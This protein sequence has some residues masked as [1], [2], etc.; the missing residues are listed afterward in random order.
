VNQSLALKTHIYYII[1]TGPIER[2]IEVELSELKNKISQVVMMGVDGV[3][4]SEKT[5]RR[6]ERGVGGIILFAHNCRHP[7]QVAE[8]T[9]GL[10]KIALN[11]EL[12]IPL[13]IAIDQEHGPVVRIREGVTPFPSPWD[14]GRSMNVSVVRRVAQITGKELLLMGINMN[15]A[16]V[17]DLHMH[18]DNQVIGKRSFGRDPHMV[19][20]MV[21]AYI[22]GLQGE[23]VAA[24]A[25]HF[26]GHGATA[27]DSHQELPI[28]KKSK[29]KLD[30]AELLPFQM[31][32]NAGVASVMTGHLL[33]PVLDPTRPATL[34]H[35]IIQGVLRRNLGFSGVVISDDLTMGALSQWGTIEEIGVEALSSG[36]DFLLVGHGNVDGLLD[37]LQRGVATGKISRARAADAIQRILMLKKHYPYRAPGDLS[38]LRQKNDLAFSQELFRGVGYGEGDPRD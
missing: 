7:S 20:E 3:T 28:I 36:V 14:L 5:T 10:Q 22:S 1:H 4:P 38:R 15:L 12:K 21:A 23:G 8:L 24:C 33:Y 27:K 17:A 2:R 35:V 9:Q 37:G 6:I 25:K 26:P 29:A 18:P 31:A 32:V 13:M 19:A 11:G 34:S 30:E 16:P